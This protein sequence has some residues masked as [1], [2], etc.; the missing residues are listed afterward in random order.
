MISTDNPHVTFMNYLG[1][2]FAE[3]GYMSSIFRK[4]I[5]PT[6][7]TITGGNIVYAQH[8]RSKY[9]RKEGKGRQNA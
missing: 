3:N 5:S 9:T 1:P 6:S 8:R 4:V 2:Y 7:N